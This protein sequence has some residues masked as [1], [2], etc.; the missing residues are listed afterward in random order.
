M[1]DIA[2]Y[3]YIWKQNIDNIIKMAEPAGQAK[4]FSIQIKI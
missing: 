4:H 2:V 1:Y 3:N